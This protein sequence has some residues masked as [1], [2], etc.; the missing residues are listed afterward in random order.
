MPENQKTFADYWKYLL[1]LPS[2]VWQ[3][4][5][6]LA[7]ATIA[8]GIVS[9]FLSFAFG[10]VP[11]LIDV[12][13]F[14]LL[15]A[16][17]VSILYGPWLFLDY[18][19]HHEKGRRRQ[20]VEIFEGLG[21]GLWWRLLLVISFKHVLVMLPFLILCFFF[22]VCFAFPPFF[23][24]WGLGLIAVCVVAWFL[25]FFTYFTPSFFYL[26]RDMSLQPLK[27]SANFVKS[28]ILYFFGLSLV[29]VAI[30]FG[31]SLVTG[32][33]NFVWSIA[34]ALF[35]G[36]FGTL[37][38]FQNGDPAQVLEQVK[39]VF[40]FGSP[41]TLVSN[42]IHLVREFL[43]AMVSFLLGQ[44]FFLYFYTPKDLANQE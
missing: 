1:S 11:I 16:G 41:V 2:Q 33:G 25:H 22:P 26:N 35:S 12:L 27:D 10:W 32:T 24:F 6:L 15:L 31:I 34:G 38:S 18:L 43:S 17:L 28:N 44:S 21:S 3:D 36:D 14:L 23:I 30:L 37:T 29:E 40:S 42:V 39:S 9:V 7:C 4:L 8:P 19:S 5:S 13:E 20:F